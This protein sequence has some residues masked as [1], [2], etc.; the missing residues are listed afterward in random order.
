MAVYLVAV[1]QGCYVLAV[2]Q[3][4]IA[5][6]ADFTPAVLDAGALGV[7]KTAFGVRNAYPLAQTAQRYRPVELARIDVRKLPMRKA[8]RLIQPFG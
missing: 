6:S 7:F 1:Q 2:K 4:G 8:Q 3:D 5:N